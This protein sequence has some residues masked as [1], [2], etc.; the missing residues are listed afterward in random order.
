MRPMRS[1]P[2]ARSCTCR[3]QRGGP[4]A[5]DAHGARARRAHAL[6][7]FAGAGSRPQGHALVSPLAR[8]VQGLTGHDNIIRLQNVLKAENDK[9]I[10]L[11]F[12]F[13][14]TVRRAAP[15]R[16][17][18]RSARRRAAAAEA[19]CPF[20]FLLAVRFASRRGCRAARRTCTR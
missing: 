12:D 19:D 8:R 6:G 14:E 9:D 1:A 7:A 16:P 10:Y 2:S 13:M 4:R 5:S 3:S 17:M 20:L 11:V 15:A 18:R